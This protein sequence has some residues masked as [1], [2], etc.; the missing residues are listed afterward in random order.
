MKILSV[1]KNKFSYDFEVQLDEKQWKVDFANAKK[2]LAKNLQIPGFRK[3]HVP[4]A[5]VDEIYPL[6]RVV[7]EA[8]NRGQR[9]LIEE[10]LKSPEFEKEDCLDSVSALDIA[11]FNGANA[12]V[13]KVTLEAV[14][15]VTGFTVKDL[16]EVEIPPFKA[17]EIPADVIKQQ[18]KQWIK[19]DAMISEKKD[20]IIAKG[21]IA[22]IDFKGY[23]DDKPFAGGEAKNYE[24]EIGSKSF[25]DNFE[26][27]LIGVKKGEKK[28]V[29]VTFPKDYGSKEL[30]GAKVKFDVTVNNVKEIEY[31]EIDKEYLKKLRITKGEGMKAI[32]DHIKSLFLQE[33]EM[34]YIDASVK[35]IQEAIMKKVKINYYPVGLLQ[36]HKNQVAKTYEDEAKKHGFNNLEGYKK[37]LNLK[38]DQFDLILTNSAKTCLEVAVCLENLMDELKV[39]IND[40]DKADYLSKLTAYFGDEKMAKQAME[41]NADYVEQQILRDKLNKRLVAEAKKVEPKKEPK[42]AEDKKEEKKADK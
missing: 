12:P 22:V 8:L 33:D 11:K 26:D 20:G 17:R 6:E 41:A 3:G 2:S 37:A 36:M 16:K 18:A 15:E 7:I 21:D 29:H 40:A 31:P 32:E 24:L 1:K 34:R 28:E 35:T 25:I 39:E 30:A 23:K 10:V 27:Q 42:K 38:D 14:P 13:V 19:Q 4:A 5:K 9:K